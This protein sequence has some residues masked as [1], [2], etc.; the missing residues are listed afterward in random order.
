MKISNSGRSSA[1]L[2]THEEKVL[3]ALQNLPSQYKVVSSPRLKFPTE[4]V[5]YEPDFVVQR[6]DGS[7]LVV[8]V[9][10]QH[11]LSMNNLSQ[12]TRISA[13]IRKEGQGFVVMVFG[14]TEEW[15]PTWKLD[16]FNELHVRT[17]MNK[18]DIVRQTL[19]EFNEL[20]PLSTATHSINDR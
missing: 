7:R 15:S 8:E 2:S 4:Q 3:S 19:Q 18:E 11:S 16:E 13:L 20:P 1:L 10:S 5:S 6:E 12:L 17:V 9:K 14:P